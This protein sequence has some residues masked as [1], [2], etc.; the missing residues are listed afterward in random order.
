MKLLISLC[1]VCLPLKH[2]RLNSAFGYRTHPL[3]GERR[4][5][6]GIDLRA[7]HDSVYAIMDGIVRYTGYDRGLG[8][9]IRLEHGAIRAVYGHLSQVFVRPLDSVS[10]GEAIGITGA[11]G[12][13]TGE[14]LHLSI[15][16]RG[17]CIDP[18][19]FF[20]QIIIHHGKNQKF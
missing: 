10:A 2:L 5:H 17:R 13:V 19:Q 20:Y 11:T 18:F 7:R 8:I 16:Y 12:R 6:D 4:L 15:L 3:S 1:L 9:H 14:H